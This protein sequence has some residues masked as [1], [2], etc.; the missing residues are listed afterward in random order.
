MADATNLRLFYS[1][2]PFRI[3]SDALPPSHT[4]VAFERLRALHIIHGDMSHV[5]LPG[6]FE[7]ITHGL[8]G[9]I[10]SNSCQS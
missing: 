6:L 3:L 8:I 9:E 4:E 1:W 2:E 7:E 5:H 10:P